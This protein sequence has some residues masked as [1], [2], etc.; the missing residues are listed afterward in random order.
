MCFVSKHAQQAVN[1]KLTHADRSALPSLFGEQVVRW[2]I[3]LEWCARVGQTT[4]AETRGCIHGGSV[5]NVRTVK[6]LVSNFGSLG[7]VFHF[8]SG[9][10]VSGN[11]WVRH[12]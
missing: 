8:L 7:T 10:R 5:K 11:D 9:S 1:R 2:F 4:V 6:H 12:A 3:V